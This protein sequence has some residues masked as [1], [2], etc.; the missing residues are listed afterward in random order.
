MGDSPALQKEWITRSNPVMTILGV[1]ILLRTRVWSRRLGL[2]GRAVGVFEEAEKPAVGAQHKGSR[3]AVQRVSVGLHR[4]IE[5]EEFL[6]L[7]ECGGIDL[8]ALRIAF[9]AHALRVPLRLGE[10][11]RAFAIGVG[12]DGLRRFGAFA[13]VLRGLL[14]AFRLHAGEARLAVLFGQI[15]AAD[16]DVDDSDAE[17]LSLAGHIVTD[18]MHYFGALIRQ[19]L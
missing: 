17:R 12:A 4:A 19:Q 15:G 13:A 5:G 16:P 10:N 1:V 6:V 18:L 2:G 7:P 9:A 11:H 8:D 3:T 14:L